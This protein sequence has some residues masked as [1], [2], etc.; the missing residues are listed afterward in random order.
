MIEM[1]ADKLIGPIFPWEMVELDPGRNETGMFF[2]WRWSTGYCQLIY[3][4]YNGEVRFY[5]LLVDRDMWE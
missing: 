5:D 3:F 1:Q 2:Y 4:M